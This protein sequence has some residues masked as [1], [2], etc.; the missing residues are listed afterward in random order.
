M[1]VSVLAAGLAAAWRPRCSRARSVSRSPR[2][3]SAARCAKASAAAPVRGLQAGG[4]RLRLAEGVAGG[5][6][7][8][9]GIGDIGR[10][11][12]R[13]PQGGQARCPHSPG[14]LKE[15]PTT[16]SAPAPPHR[17]ARPW[18]TPHWPRWRCVSSRPPAP[19]PRRPAPGCSEAP[20]ALATGVSSFSAGGNEIVHR[21]GRGAG[22]ARIVGER[23]LG[24]SEPVDLEIGDRRESRSAAGSGRARNPNPNRRL[25]KNRKPAATAASR[26][27]APP[28]ASNAARGGIDRGL[29]GALAPS[30]AAPTAC[31]L[32]AAPRS[33]A[34]A[35]GAGSLFL[36]LGGLGGLRRRRRPSSSSSRRRSPR[37]PA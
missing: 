25:P 7:R 24:R 32:A 36:R 15:R 5:V 23:A 17:A 6:Q 4:K 11:L 14:S 20:A 9:G 29:A 34:A 12:D 35:S 3:S 26:A 18:R 1:A 28:P 33:S 31:F 30:C 19:S 16:I 8:L 21:G 13:G 27:T 2:F 37:R 22:L 10:R